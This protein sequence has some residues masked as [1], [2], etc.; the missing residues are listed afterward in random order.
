MH[1]RLILILVLALGLLGLPSAS[2]ARRVGYRDGNG[3]WRVIDSSQWT[4]TKT[5]PAEGGPRLAGTGPVFDVT[6][7]DV[8]QHD[9]RG[10]DDPSQGSTR[11]ATISAVFS[12]ISTK[13]TDSGHCQVE[14]M[15][16]ETDGSGFLAAAGPFFDVSAPFTSGFA[17]AHITTGTDPDPTIPD[18]QAT[19]DFGWNWNSGTGASTANQSDLYSVLLHEL[20]HGLGLISLTAPDGTSSFSPNKVFSVWDKFLFTG[21][22][23][24]LWSGTG[25]F[26]G[27]ASD[28]LGHDGGIRFHGPKAVSVYGGGYPPIYAP[29]PYEDGSSIGHWDDKTVKGP[30][31]MTHAISFGEQKRTYAPFELQALADIGYHL[32]T[33]PK[34]AARHW[35]LFQ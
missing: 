29:D 15:P 9:G 24:Q 20:T 19:V 6:F 25:N 8:T 12:Y 10:F 30:A 14:F 35:E 13:L 27:S 22:G 2:Q 32:A 33:P 26:L 18:I 31:V 23:K 21:N 4:G 5:F 11:R 1:C 7:D 17:F 16:S 28:L 3:N 34:N